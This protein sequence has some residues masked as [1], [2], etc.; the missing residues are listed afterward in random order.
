M[1]KHKKPFIRVTKTGHDFTMKDCEFRGD[2][3]TIKTS[4]TNTRLI[5]V[6]HFGQKIKDNSIFILIVVGVI[7]GIIVLVF[8]YGFFVK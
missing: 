8:E 5:R 1:K 2:R 6:K 7:T 3:P 4:A